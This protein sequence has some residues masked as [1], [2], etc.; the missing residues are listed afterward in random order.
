MRVAYTVLLLLS[1]LFVTDSVVSTHR[2]ISAP[3]CTLVA[4]VERLKTSKAVFSGR[5]IEIKESEGI[6]VVRFSVSKSWKYVRASEVTVTNYVHHEGPYFHQ[7]K[8]YLVYAH[9]R[10]GKLSTGGC[11]GTM[12]GES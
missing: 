5:V 9:L 1:A 8:T 6:Q 3:K 7:G 11:S 2:R 4:A 12:H 10:K